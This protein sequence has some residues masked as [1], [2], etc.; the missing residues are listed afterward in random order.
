MIHL[1]DTELKLLLLELKDAVSF[2]THTVLK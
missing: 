1:A 2:V